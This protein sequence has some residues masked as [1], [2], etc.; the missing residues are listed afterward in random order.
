MTRYDRLVTEPGLRARKKLQT[1]RRIEEAALD[2]IERNG[3]DAVTVQDITAA[4]DVAPRTFFR[5][6]DTKDDVV[7][8]DYGDRLERLLAILR[9][10]PVTEAPWDSLREAFRTVIAD[11]TAEHSDMGR[12]IAVMVASPSVA[13]R[14]LQLQ[15]GWEQDLA[16]EIGRRRPAGP[17]DATPS[18]LAA[19]ALAVMRAAIRQWSSSPEELDLPT[20]VEQCFDHLASGL[21]N[22]QVPNQRTGHN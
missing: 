13:A 20:F 21:A 4:A 10:R 22:T 9:E 15:I 16:A 2:L 6:F 3:I 19:A 11:D 14:S 7:L 8:A 1:R 17:G 12:R 5:Y 18:L